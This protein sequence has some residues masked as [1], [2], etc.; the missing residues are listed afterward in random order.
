MA[1]WYKI[2]FVENNSNENTSESD[3]IGWQRQPPK[4]LSLITSHSGIYEP[5]TTCG[6]FTTMDCRMAVHLKMV[7]S[8]WWMNNMV[9]SK[10]IAI[11]GRGM[12][13]WA[14]LR[15]Q[16]PLYQYALTVIPSCISNYILYGEWDEII[17][18]LP[19][20]NGC[21]IGM[22]KLFHLTLHNGCNYL[23]MLGL[24]W[25]HISKKWPWGL[26]I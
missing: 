26:L 18:P 21:T 14:K 22:D 11:T 5:F 16:G 6:E 24:K 17:Y 9:S 12:F 2:N 10:N 25:N 4:A 1:M 20:V 8:W 3:V 23:S 13:Q 19:N 7:C 15:Y